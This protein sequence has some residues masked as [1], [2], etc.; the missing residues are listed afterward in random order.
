MCNV[1]NIQLLH[2]FSS[3]NNASKLQ[4][5]DIMLLTTLVCSKFPLPLQSIPLS[6]N[7]TPPPLAHDIIKFD[8]VHIKPKDCPFED[9]DQD[10][11][12]S[13]FGEVRSASLEIK[14]N[15]TA[16]SMSESADV[17]YPA[18]E[19]QSSTR[20]SHFSGNIDQM[21]KGHSSDS[22]TSEKYYTPDEIS[23]DFTV[24]LSRPKHFHYSSLRTTQYFF[25]LS[26]NFKFFFLS[27]N[28]R[29]RENTIVG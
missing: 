18:S 25:Q 26:W 20:E 17:F 8:D 29:F 10:W 6:V 9:M 13:A 7:R 28:F 1:V 5:P 12:S 2:S 15:K 23:S 3:S 14:F 11:S 16:S 27:G 4:A 21:S 24:S 22:V 19:E